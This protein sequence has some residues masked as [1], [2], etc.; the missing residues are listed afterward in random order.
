MEL[1]QIYELQTDFNNS[2]EYYRNSYTIWEKIFKDRTTETND[3]IDSS[4]YEVVITL[5][6]K[7]A[8]L[9][10]KSDNFQNAYELL[11]AVRIYF[12]YLFQTE[13]K[14]GD[15]LNDKK[16]K[17]INFKKLLIKYVSLNKDL[18]RYL[19]ELLQLEV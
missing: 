19:D 18:T 11:K 16:K 6:I 14:Y 2:I 10:E 8:E 5:S 12:K 15:C 7:L 9:F 3:H 13:E 1:A 4:S 17:K